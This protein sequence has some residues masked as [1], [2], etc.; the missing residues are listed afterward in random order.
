[1]AEKPVVPVGRDLGHRA[2]QS[3]V[4]AGGRR[5]LGSARRLEVLDL[6]KTTVGPCFLSLTTETVSTTETAVTSAEPRHRAGF[7]QSVA[8]RARC[9]RTT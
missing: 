1:V 9:P 2:R 7:G 5:V 8:E 4:A 3:R 6:S